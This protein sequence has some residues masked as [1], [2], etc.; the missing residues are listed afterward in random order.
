MGNK[1]KEARLLI[2]KYLFEVAKQNGIT[3]KEIQAATGIDQ[4]NIS[5]MLSGQHCPNMDTFLKICDVVGV[6]IFIEEKNSKEPIA[7]IMR[8][9]WERPD[10]SN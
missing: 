10:Q 8:R 3:Q 9:R 2:V 1:I 5:K 4:A 7:E 6:Y